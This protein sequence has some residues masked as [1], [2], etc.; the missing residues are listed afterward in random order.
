MKHVG[1]I[2]CMQLTNDHKPLS[3]RDCILGQDS[4]IVE[5]REWPAKKI[6]SPLHHQEAVE[7]VSFSTDGTLL[8]TGCTESNTYTWD[9][10]LIMKEFPPNFA[11]I[12]IDVFCQL[13]ADARY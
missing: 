3:R 9:V 11:W 1:N 10:P 7:C 12:P 5:P 8:A 13:L 2:K 4:A 6:G